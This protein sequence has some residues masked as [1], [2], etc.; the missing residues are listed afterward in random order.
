VRH[1]EIGRRASQSIN[2]VDHHAFARELAARSI[3]LLKNAGSVL[4]LRP[5][6]ALNIALIGPT[7]DRPII[8]GFGSSRI[9]PSRIDRLEDELRDAAATGCEFACFSGWSADTVLRSSR[10][11]EAVAGAAAA[12]VALLCV[13]VPEGDH[14][15]EE[16]DRP[17]LR[18][19]DGLDELIERVAAIQPNTVVILFTPDAIL[20]PWIDKVPVVVAPFF[21]GQGMAHALAQILFGRINPSGKLTTSFPRREEDLPAFPYHPGD[22]QVLWYG[23]DIFPGYRFFDRRKVE[24]LFPFGHGLSFT[25]FEYRA[26]TVEKIVQRDRDFVRAR[27]TLTNAGDRDGH[28]ICQ[29]YASWAQPFGNDPVRELRAFRKIFL[30]AGASCEV[31]MLVAADDFRQW[32]SLSGEDSSGWGFGPQPLEIGIGASSR[33]IHLTDTVR[34]WEMTP[35]RRALDLF[36]LPKEVLAEDEGGGLMSDFLTRKLGISPAEAQAFLPVLQNSFLGIGTTLQWFAGNRISNG[37]I[38]ELLDRIQENTATVKG[39]KHDRP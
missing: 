7:V 27:F 12:D 28:E 29:L 3:V 26:L 22:S 39:S 10:I 13:N 9:N 1:V 6:V 4:P 38:A 8:Q 30:D 37:D 23:E 31:E 24:P 5:D 18:L 2:D 35:R 34:D 20:M 14:G 19:A 16:T 15:G 36:S 33:A 32:Q 11:E 25:R 21:A 17:H